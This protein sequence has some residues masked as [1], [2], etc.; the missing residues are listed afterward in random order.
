MQYF[1]ITCIKKCW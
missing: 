1:V